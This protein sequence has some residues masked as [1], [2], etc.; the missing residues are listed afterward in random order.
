MLPS[1]THISHPHHTCMSHPLSFLHTQRLHTEI[2]NWRPG[3]P[4]QIAISH[5]LK[6]K[7]VEY[8][9]KLLCIDDY[10]HH[11][12]PQSWREDMLGDQHGPLLVHCMLWML[13]MV[14]NTSVL[15]VVPF[16]TLHKPLK[17]HTHHQPPLPPSK[18]TQGLGVRYANP[19]T[20]SRTTSTAPAPSSKHM[21][22]QMRCSPRLFP[23]MATP[24]TLMSLMVY[25]KRYTRNR[26]Y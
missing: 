19:S 9:E 4:N 5:L 18:H 15:H 21:P 22:M 11:L 24:L 20:A 14:V 23:S 13:V 17:T 1:C 10:L 12:W 16:D 8:R 2:P 3:L 26:I 6:S 25:W 7:P